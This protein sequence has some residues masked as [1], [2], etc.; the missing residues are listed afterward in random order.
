MWVSDHPSGS[1]VIISQVDQVRG[2][3]PVLWLVGLGLTVALF[4]VQ[5]WAL[6][7]YQVPLQVLLVW[8]LLGW[9]GLF[10]LPK[11]SR[12]WNPYPLVHWVV[13]AIFLCGIA[14][15]NLVEGR[16]WLRFQQIC[17]GI[18][19]AFISAQAVTSLRGR[20][21]LV[22]ALTSAATTSSVIALLQSRGM[23]DWSWGG[24]LYDGLWVR[25]PS[26]LESFPV[27]YSYSVVGIGIVLLGSGFHDL[28]NSERLSLFPPRMALV[29]GGIILLG[30]VAALSRS[31][32]LA[33]IVGVTLLAM[34]MWYIK[35][36]FILVTYLTVGLFVLVGLVSVD[37]ITFLDRLYDKSK[38]AEQDMRMG[39]TFT[40]FTPVILQYPLGIPESVLN[41]EIHLRTPSNSAMR[42]T[43]K[44]LKEAFVMSEGYEPHNLFLSIGLR[45]GVPGI[46][47]LGVIYYVLINRA[48]IVLRR[49]HP[50]SKPRI[51]VL[52]VI[53][54]VAN[55][56]LLV[57]AFFHNASILAGEMR[58]WIWIGVLSILTKMQG[59][60]NRFDHLSDCPD[61]HIVA[62]VEV[63]CSTEC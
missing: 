19:L 44:E 16:S 58:G 11:I 23:A 63:Q 32:V 40:L 52:V 48:V 57:H 37:R 46:I 14:T 50:S 59:E 21:A 26:G 34:G 1:V 13:I 55:V 9:F 41:L 28:K 2:D 25:I 61:R 7:V 12:L 53:F 31:G 8:L 17:T 60:Q 6:T 30:N 39:A 4:T 36:R 49:I 20:R 62:D 18:A 56:G 24:T 5:P 22:L 43:T 42:N 35:R 38:Q 15:Q 29:C 51:S 3:L 27:A 33:I 47:A 10:R 45:Y 54:L